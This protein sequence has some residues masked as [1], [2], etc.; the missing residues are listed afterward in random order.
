MYNVYRTILYDH[1]GMCL[2]FMVR[3]EVF[4]WYMGCPFP[5]LR[6][7]QCTP[8]LPGYRPGEEE[9]ISTKSALVKRLEAIAGILQLL[10]EG[11]R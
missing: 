11:C 3:Q 4:R 10:R 1:L 6:S 2:P 9:F 7:V 8:S 5:R